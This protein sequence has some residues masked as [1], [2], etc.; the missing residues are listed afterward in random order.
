M[1]RDQLKTGASFRGVPFSTVDAQLQIGRRAVVHQFPMRD[2]PFVEDLGRSAR[3]FSVEA[4]VLGDDYLDR[5]NALIQAIEQSGPGE[6]IHPR[7]GTLQVQVVD[8][9]ERETPREGGIARFSIT[10]VEAGANTFPRV[11][12]STVA[13]VDNASAE[14]E[15]AASEAFGQ[16]FSV[17]GASVLAEEALT[18]LQKDLAGIASTVRQVT[19]FESAG[20]LVRTVGLITSDVSTLLR[21]PVTLVQ[22]FRSLYQDLTL[23]L[24][25]PLGAIADFRSTF[26]SNKRPSADL[27]AAARPGSTRARLLANESARAD[28]QRR[29]ALSN[30]AR[31][32][33][34]ALQASSTQEPAV[35]T[36]SK[37]VQLRDELLALVD[38]EL[39]ENDP[40]A[41]VASALVR[42]RAAVTRDVAERAEQRRQ[43]STFTPMTVLPSVVLAHRI[44][45]DAARAEELELRN[46]VRHPAFVPARPLEVLR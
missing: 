33:A 26:G 12:Q 14:L 37:A 1:W 39:E 6:L 19:S 15:D 8:A 21:T 25:R 43:A 10:F 23:A 34:L 7:Y 22:R 24:K 32:L 35:A 40:P 5:R 42:L 2:E 41:E 16:E 11:T 9:T 4:Y 31:A 3:T 30:H 36:A 44:Y 17:E 46:G 29:L 27:V 38:V 28:L 20:D 18:A 13:E 45:Q